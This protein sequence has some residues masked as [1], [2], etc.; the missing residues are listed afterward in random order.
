MYWLRWHYHVKDIAGAPYKI[1]KKRNKTTESPTVSSRGQTTVILC[2]AITIASHCQTTT[3]K[4]QSSALNGTSSATV[5][6][7]QTTAGCST[8]ALCLRSSW[9]FD[10]CLHFC[11]HP[12]LYL[13]VSWAWW[14]WPSTWF[15]N[16]RPSV[17]WHCWSGH[18]T[19]VTRKIV[20]KMTYNVSS[21][22][23]NST[24]P[25]QW[26]RRKMVTWPVFCDFIGSCSYLQ[27]I[28]TIYWI[29]ATNVHAVIHL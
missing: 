28:H 18:L 26:N 17:L 16:H 8:H 14:D 19:P 29:S 4:V 2:S 5:H 11:L 3:R 27:Y 15:T 12:S 22:M 7:W 23:L 10:T 1:K 9:C 21:G 6:S 24:I 13:L 20:S 25:Y